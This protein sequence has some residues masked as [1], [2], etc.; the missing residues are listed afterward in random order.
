MFRLPMR[1][2]MLSMLA[3]MLLLAGC[4]STRVTNHWRDPQFAG[5]PP[6]RV[7][8][9]GISES[10]SGRRV[11]E[12]SFVNTLL[13]AGT[14]ARA[15]YPQLPQ[16]GAI[17]KAQL[18][19]AIRA[20]QSQAVLVTRLLKTER[21]VDVIPGAPMPVMGGFYGWYGSAWA[22]MP[23]TITQYDV[24]TL[25]TTLWDVKAEKAIWS[26]QSEGFAPTDIAKFST[27]LAQ[28]L[29]KQ[30]QQDGVLASQ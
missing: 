9:V 16:T 15:S 24:V 27:G 23:P 8:V 19:E 1:F 6:Q 13:A 14:P 2:R 11:F 22:T 28:Q 18:V 26:G 12:D 4:A 5:P 21:Q 25:E 7:L 10:E 17:P 3:A 20:S 30:M 29:I